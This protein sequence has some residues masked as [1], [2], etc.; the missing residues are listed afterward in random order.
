MAKK[1][2]HAALSSMISIHESLPSMYLRAMSLSSSSSRRTGSEIF[3]T[4]HH[5]STVRGQTENTVWY[6]FDRRELY[7][8]KSHTNSKKERT[9][10]K[11]F[12]VKEDKVQAE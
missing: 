8:N 6:F 10:S 11:T 5:S 12:D 7:Q 9:H 1:A 2:A 3:I 4:T